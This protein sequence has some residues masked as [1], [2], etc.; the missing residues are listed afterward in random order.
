MTV[1]PSPASARTPGLGEHL[2]QAAEQTPVLGEDVQFLAQDL[3]VHRGA[4]L[5]PE[6]QFLQGRERRGPRPPFQVGEQGVP[7]PGTDALGRQVVRQQPGVRG[8]LGRRR[9]EVRGGDSRREGAIPPDDLVEQLVHAL[10]RGKQ[11]LPGGALHRVAAQPAERHAGRVVDPDLPAQHL[12]RLGRL[13]PGVRGGLVHAHV[14]DHPVRQPTAEPDAVP[15]ERQVGGLVGAAGQP[16][17]ADGLEAPVQHQWM[18]LQ[19]VP[20]ERLRE[21]HL[22]DRLAG[23]GPNP[24]QRAERRPRSIPVAERAR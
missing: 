21:G 9:Q 15:A 22:G 6:A 4:R 24:F 7:V 20:A 19:L 1:N 13:R 23:A 14:A 17:D 8:H 2:E 16:R 11:R 10:D 12:R 18:D 3:R 5:S